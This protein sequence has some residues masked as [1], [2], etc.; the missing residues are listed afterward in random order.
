MIRRQDSLV[1]YEGIERYDPVQIVPKPEGTEFYIPPEREGV[2]GQPGVRIIERTSSD[3]TVLVHYATSDSSSTDT[4]VRIQEEGMTGDSLNEIRRKVINFCEV[5]AQFQSVPQ[6]VNPVT[7]LES[8]LKGI[9]GVTAIQYTDVEKTENIIGKI[10]VELG[11]LKQNLLDSETRLVD[12]MISIL[13]DLLD[14]NVVYF[15]SYPGAIEVEKS[16]PWFEEVLQRILD[17]REERA[18]IFAV[19]AEAYS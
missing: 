4:R 10:I 16:I 17:A 18:K 14:L 9:T 7:S 11:V 15:G 6:I 5:F 3:G 1:G 13:K 8:V 12:E 19:L 2:L